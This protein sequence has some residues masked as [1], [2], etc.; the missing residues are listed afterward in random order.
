MGLEVRHP[1]G[2]ER[3]P[4]VLGVARLTADG[5]FDRVI[6]LDRFGFDDVRGGRFGRGGRVLEGGRELF[7]Q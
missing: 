3:L 5:A 2:W 4:F 6:R 7:P 1:L